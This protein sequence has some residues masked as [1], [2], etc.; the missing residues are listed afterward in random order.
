MFYQNIRSFMIASSSE[1]YLVDY[2]AVNSLA[3]KGR[4][5][6]IIGTEQSMN[7][8]SV[9]ITSVPVPKVTI[10]TYREKNALQ[11]SISERNVFCVVKK[12][13]DYWWLRDDPIRLLIV[14]KTSAKYCNRIYLLAHA[15]IT[16]YQKKYFTGESD[17]IVIMSIIRTE[18]QQTLWKFQMI[19]IFWKSSIRTCSIGSLCR[20]SV[21]HLYPE[22]NQG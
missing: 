10:A 15:T 9:L 3:L 8:V 7:K 14:L 2:L 13:T 1:D 20:S 6:I 21:L 5:Q 4:K 19:V 17:Q 16:F 22:N 18:F 11:K 12:M